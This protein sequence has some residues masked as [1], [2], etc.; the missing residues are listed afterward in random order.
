MVMITDGTGG[1]T[2]AS[3]S[4]SNKLRTLATSHT[5][6][7]FH[8][9]IDGQA[10]IANTGD[11]ANTLTLATGN[12]YN[13]L[14]LRND[15]SSLILIIQKIV[16]SVDTANVVYLLQKNMTL[17]VV[18]DNNVHT[19]VNVNFASGNSADVLCHNWDET[20]TTGVG[21][22][23]VGTLTDSTILDVG[24][25]I[26]PIDGSIILGQNDN[27]VIRLVNGTGG[28]AEA[29]TSIRFYFDT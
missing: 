15:S 22:L 5:E 17:G 12:T 2:S 24:A 6:E 11:T 7:H 19:P 13:M 1:G 18:A 23:T 29:S 9:D 3:V 25:S 4:A 14:F 8:S 16:V 21:G 10:Y 26:F 28:N 27:V 20:G